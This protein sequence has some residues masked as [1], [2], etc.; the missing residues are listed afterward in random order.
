MSLGSGLAFG[1]LI[2]Y[3]AYRVSNNPRDF[4][5]LLGKTINYFLY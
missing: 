2:A 5:F 3:G 1:G 4:I